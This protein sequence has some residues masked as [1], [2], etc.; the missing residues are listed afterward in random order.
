MLSL[1]FVLLAG[2]LMIAACKSPTAP[3]PHNPGPNPQPFPGTTVQSV[4]LPGT[5]Q[6]LLVWI[7]SIS[8]AKGTQLQVG[9]TPF[10]DFTCGGPGGYTAVIGTALMSGENIR[11]LDGMP[12]SVGPDFWSRAGSS[13]RV[14]TKCD[15]TGQRGVTVK[16]VTPDITHIAF[17]VW[18]AQGDQLPD[19]N[20]PPDKVFKEDV[21][22]GKP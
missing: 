7:T 14:N 3:S 2:S 1:V 13:Y 10:V 17:F 4:P 16:D 21:R 5:D 20:R 22:W 9:Q 15:S 11:I 19:L 18:V 8:P 6:P 12:V